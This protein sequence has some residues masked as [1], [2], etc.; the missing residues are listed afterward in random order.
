[1]SSSSSDCGKDITIVQHVSHLAADSV[2]NELRLTYESGSDVCDTLVVR[3]TMTTVF[4]NISI[5]RED[6]TLT[7]SV[8]TA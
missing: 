7:E 4:I 2:S 3:M 5:F 6:Q 8:H 1:M